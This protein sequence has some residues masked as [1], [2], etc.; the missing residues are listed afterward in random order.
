MA[1]V[2]ILGFVQDEHTF[3]TLSFMKTQLRNQLIKHLPL[4]VDM[5]CQV[6]YHLQ[7]F[8][9]DAGYNSWK[10]DEEWQCDN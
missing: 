9:Y 3:S 1:I 7:T 5:K 4:V 10:V 6:F 8:P 2:T